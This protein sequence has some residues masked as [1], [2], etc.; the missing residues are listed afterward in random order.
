M[1]TPALALDVKDM[2]EAIADWAEKTTGRRP[3]PERIGH[4]QWG[5]GQWYFETAPWEPTNPRDDHS[6]KGE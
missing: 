6:S 1:P 3:E 4:T 5:D 2:K